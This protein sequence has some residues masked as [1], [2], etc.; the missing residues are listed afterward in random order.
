MRGTYQMITAA[1]ERF[2][3]QIP[4]FTLTEPYTTVH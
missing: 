4:P 2:D 3:V 1:Q